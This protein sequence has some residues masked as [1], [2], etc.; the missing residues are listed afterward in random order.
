M[1]TYTYQ[2]LFPKQSDS[3]TVFT[4][5][6]PASDILAFAKI[7]RIGRGE[8][9]TL[10]G[11]Q[12]PQVSAHIR[13]IRD[14]LEQPQ[15]VLPNSI[16]VAFTSGITFLPDETDQATSVKISS[17]DQTKGFVVDGQQRLTALSNIPDREFEVC[18]SGILCGSEEELRKQFILINNSRPLPKSLIYELLPTVDG[19][20]T[21]LSSRA[22]AAALLETLNFD[23]RSSLHGMINLHTNPQ[24]FIK[25]TSMQ[26][27][28]MNSLSDGALRELSHDNKDAEDQMMLLSNFFEAV[29]KTF[30]EAWNGQKPKTSRLVH[31]AGIVAMGFVMEQIFSMTRSPEVSD[32]LPHLEKLKPHCAWTQGDWEFSPG[33]KKPWNKIQFI[34]SDYLELSQYLLRIVKRKSHS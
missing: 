6:A 32:F 11:F 20:P 26:K 5:C 15:A 4:F 27:V 23:S 19:L 10:R 28:I 22:S 30:P 12:R 13:E 21:R 31:S 2:A 17:D 8:D 14:Y 33:Y 34:A 1:K 7:D 25:D 24:G 16:V 29:A 18:V 3:L 9:G